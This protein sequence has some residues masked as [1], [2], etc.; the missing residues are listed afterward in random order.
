MRT[1]DRR[2]DA[3]ARDRILDSALK[4]FGE[5]GFD[6]TTT[7][8]VA[9]RAGVN[10]VTLFRLFGSK[11]GLFSAVIAERSHLAEVT[12]TV[13]LEAKGSIDAQ[14]SNNIRMVL[15]TLRA[16][17]H[18]FMVLLGDAWRHPKTRTMIA[19]ATTDR[20]LELVARFI[21]AQMEAGRLRRADPM[22]TA[23]ALMG[24][25]QAYFITTELLA[26]KRPSEEEDEKVIRG[27][28]SL[29]MD[30]M[31]PGGEDA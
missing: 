9:D 27:F 3:S 5:K 16:H 30:G 1:P 11:K 2:P 26:G 14:I 28:V 4:W 21:S 18:L 13:N 24:M 20:G 19:E 12:R 29:F 23:R 8:E 7:K 22:V 10:E 25:V 31:R 15:Q 17:K 6:G